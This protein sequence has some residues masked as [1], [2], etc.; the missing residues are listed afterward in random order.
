LSSRVRRQCISAGAAPRQT[1]ILAAVLV[2][3]LS[4]CA[5]SAQEGGSADESKRRLIRKTKGED[6][7][8]VMSRIIDHMRQAGKRLADTFDPG[9]ATQEIQQQA[10]RD[11][12][13]AIKQAKQN[14]RASRAASDQNREK[15]GE[16]KTSDDAEGDEAKG[17]ADSTSGEDGP[18]G[19][20]GDIEV[21]KDGGTMSER[22]RQWGHLPPH[23]RDEIIDSVDDEFLEKYRRQ[24][25]RYYETLADPELEQ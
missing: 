18:A 11:L 7:S 4:F 8:D 10:L 17:Q 14:M 22:R 1:A 9:E 23:D 25:E 24:I 20:G 6:D 19:L 12:D 3:C 21:G 5:T 13:L 15:R 2:S 16:G